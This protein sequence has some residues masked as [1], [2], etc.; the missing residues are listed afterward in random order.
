MFKEVFL[1]FLSPTTSLQSVNSCKDYTETTLK[2]FPDSLDSQGVSPGKGKRLAK[3]KKDDKL[4]R[5]LTYIRCEYVKVLGSH[6]SVVQGRLELPPKTSSCARYFEKTNE[7][8][9]TFLSF[10]GPLSTVSF[11][12]YFFFKFIY[13]GN[14][15]SPRGA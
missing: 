15:H 5:D 10:A 11:I 1:M 8:S 14:L 3:L 9:P 13:L 12:L 2:I 7:T 4:S 6:I